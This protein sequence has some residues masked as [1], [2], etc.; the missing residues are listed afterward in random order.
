MMDS[1]SSSTV[2]KAFIACERKVVY[3]LN[4]VMDTI[5][6]DQEESTLTQGLLA[7]SDEDEK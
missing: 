7:P 3:V 5:Y 1:S 2:L 4:S 6:D